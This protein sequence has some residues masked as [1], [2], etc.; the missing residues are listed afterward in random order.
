MFV[1]EFLIKIFEAPCAEI[2][3][4]ILTSVNL[5]VNCDIEDGVHK[6]EPSELMEEELLMVELIKA[7]VKSIKAAWLKLKNPPS[8]PETEPED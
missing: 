6:K 8:R 2:I 4:E 5:R 3:I 1:P 7:K